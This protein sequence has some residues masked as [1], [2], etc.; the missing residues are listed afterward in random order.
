MRKTKQRTS[1]TA[2]RPVEALIHVIRDQKVMLDSDLA[3]LYEVP[4]KRL[5]EAVRRNLERFP[6]D[7]MFQ[8]T[9]AE[10]DSL[11]SQ[12]ATSNLGRGGRRYAPYAFT[13]EGVAMLSSVLRSPR[14]VQM[15]IL[16]MRAFLR[17][18]EMIAANKDLAARV[19]KL[20]RGH[21]RTVSVIEVLVEDID[22][23]AGEL[24]QMKALPAPKKRRIGFHVSP[25]RD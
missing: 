7:F 21:S 23:L 13:Q 6:K 15:N 3:A 11:R 17:L 22:Q 8:L 4:T 2:P 19:E 16:I 10:R 20:E 12:I 14:A 24:K 18:R 5:N 1:P 9:L 25:D